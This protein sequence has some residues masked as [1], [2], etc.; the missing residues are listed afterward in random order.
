MSKRIGSRY[1]R[2]AIR[3]LEAIGYHCTKAGASLGAFDV[4]AIG[5]RDVRAIQVK[6]GLK[7]Y[8]PPLEREAIELIKVCSQVSKELWKFYKFKRHPVI[9]IIK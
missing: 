4:I 5:P 6:G 9:E 3:I 1:E 7:P 2:R 8:L